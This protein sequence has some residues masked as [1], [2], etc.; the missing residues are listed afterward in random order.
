MIILLSGSCTATD[1]RLS[2]LSR[3]SRYPMIVLNH[4]L[5]GPS[6]STDGYCLEEVVWKVW[7]SGENLASDF[8]ASTLFTL[9]TELSRP[10][11][12][13]Q[14]NISPPVCLAIKIFKPPC[15]SQC[16]SMAFISRHISRLQFFAQFLSNHPSFCL[17]KHFWGSNLKVCPFFD[18]DAAL[19]RW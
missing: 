3:L 9:L 5:I 8:I 17:K 4:R 18:A 10:A 16:A 2:R 1:L 15:N 13:Y 7:K 19:Q 6:K 11:L 12:V 14:T